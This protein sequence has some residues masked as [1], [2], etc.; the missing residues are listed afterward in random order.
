MGQIMYACVGSAWI[1]SEVT[2]DTGLT[3]NV[4]VGCSDCNFGTTLADTCTACSDCQNG[5]TVNLDCSCMCSEQYTGAT[6]ETDIDECDLGLASCSDGGVCQ[7]TDGGFT[8]ACP[9]PCTGICNACCSSPCRKGG[10]CISNDPNTFT[11]MCPPGF[12]GQMC[13]T[14]GGLCINSPCQNSGF[15][16]NIG[17][18]T[19]Y[20][21]V[22]AIGYT[23]TNCETEIDNCASN[24]CLHSGYCTSNPTGY[25]CE[26]LQG[27]TGPD[28][29]EIM[30]NCE[31]GGSECGPQGTC[32]TRVVGPSTSRVCT[33][34]PGFTGDFCSE[35]ITDCMSSDPLCYHRSTCSPTTA[36]DTF[37]INCTCIDNWEGFYCTECQPLVCQNGGVFDPQC[38]GCICT[39]LWT[40]LTCD[41]C[42]HVIEDG[43][44]IPECTRERFIATAETNNTCYACGKDYCSS[45]N[46]RN[47]CTSC[48]SGYYLLDVRC[49]TKLPEDSD[50]TGE[51]VGIIL[52]C[53]AGAVLVLIIVFGLT[54]VALQYIRKS[55][56]LEMVK[57]VPNS[58]YEQQTVLSGFTKRA[59]T[60]FSTGGHT[61]GIPTGN[62][63]SFPTYHEMVNEV[64]TYENDEA[65]EE[66]PSDAYENVDENAYENAEVK[67]TNNS[68]DED[69]DWL[70]PPDD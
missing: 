70:P 4:M 40:G 34:S 48:Y 26:C 64:D 2:L 62:R 63:S 30:L 51:T 67:Q 11:C 41:T 59:S 16:R 10:T 17:D 69:E 25:T 20:D 7:N 33:C 49:R 57:E 58:N 3:Q 60:H 9:V 52:G 46:G 6:C 13:E 18:G 5:G 27:F 22:C 50:N 37:P 55:A 45:C 65:H 61:G 19:Q 39:T 14:F 29:G 44:C 28:C 42:N 68:G 36:G 53:I 24:P 38:T 35:P 31:I 32:T 21:C 56:E 15:C 12:T 1:P 66:K 54:F 23:G 43:R 8:C 47:H